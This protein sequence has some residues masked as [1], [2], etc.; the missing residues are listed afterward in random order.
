[1]FAAEEQLKLRLEALNDE[2]AQLRREDAETHPLVVPVT[3]MIGGFGISAVTVLFTVLA[4]NEPGSY[5][6]T[7]R[8]PPLV[9]NSAAP[10]LVGVAVLSGAVGISGLIFTNYRLRHRPH[11]ARLRELSE[12]N[13][14]VRR[15]LKQVRRDLKREGWSLAPRLPVLSAGFGLQASCAF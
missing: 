8:N 3:M 11:S 5:L 6:I 12:Q 1:M 15:Q 4:Y 13:Q 10:A 9:S 2:E 14:S 7:S